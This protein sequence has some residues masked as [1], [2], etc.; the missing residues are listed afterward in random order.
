MS[1]RFRTRP[2]AQGF[3]LIALLALITAGIL[4]FLVG[5]LD[6]ATIQRKRD[7][8]TALALA[9]AKEALIGWSAANASVPGRLPCP[10]DLSLIGTPNE[11]RAQSSCNVLPTIGRLPWRTLGIDRL[12]DGYGEPLWYALSPGFRLSPINSET[13]AQLTIDGIPGSAVAIVLS[14]GPTL[15]GQLRTA[16]T[17]TTP[18]AV[19]S[20]LDL[21]NADGDAA[22]ASSGPTVT[23]NDKLLAISHQDL[24]GVVE[25]RVANE[26][27]QALLTY[28][29]GSAANIAAN[30]T[31]I[32]P[33]GARAFPRPATFNDASCL[34]YSDIPVACTSAAIGNQGRIPANPAVP[35][36]N[37][38]GLSILRGTSGASGNWFQTNGWRELVYVAISDKCMGPTPDCGEAG[39]LLSINGAPDAKVV[40]IVGGTALSF[41][42]RSPVPSQKLIVANYLE[43]D[44]ATTGDNSFASSAASPTFNDIVRAIR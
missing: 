36:T 5:Q 38:D 33:G 24:F 30:Q 42:T 17:A 20:Y 32:L 44:N 4:Y 22:F 29:C 18:P 14:P 27:Q 6:A 15:P 25:Q 13:P 8:S 3:A 11:G 23:F 41:Q 9:Q 28:F 34:G 2:P 26:V 39:S 31:C 1:R 10:E 35:W 16:V 21:T 40:I 12:R 7:E 43:G 19:A 37:Y